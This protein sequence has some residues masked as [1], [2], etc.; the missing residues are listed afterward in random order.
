MK[1]GAYVSLRGSSQQKTVIRDAGQD[2]FA[3]LVVG[4]DGGDATA[5]ELQLNAAGTAVV[6]TV[7]RPT[8]EVQTLFI[9]PLAD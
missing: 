2:H 4:H 7:K 1:H 5:Y 8:R 3:G 9:D 6:L